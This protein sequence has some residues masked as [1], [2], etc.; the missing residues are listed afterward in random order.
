MQLRQLGRSPFQVAPLCLGGNV[1]GWTADEPTSFA[2][3]DAY[4][5]AGGNFV[6]T[7]DVYAR[8][9]PGNS[10][11]ESE[12]VLG[13]WMAARGNRGSVVIATKV[14]S[15]MGPDARGLSRR[16]IMTAVEDSLRRLQ[17][18][19]IDLYQAHR[20]DETTP[21]DETLGAFDEL[22]RQGKVRTIGASNFTRARLAEAHGVSE[23][24][25]YARY[26][27]LQPPYSLVDRGTYEPELE[28]YCREHDVGVITY[29]SLASGFLAGKYRPGQPLP[30][31][32][33]AQGIQSKFMNERGFRVLAE[34]DR[35]AAAHGVTP[36]Q[37]ALAW[38][39]ARPG[40]TAPIASATSVTQL[41]ELLGAIDLKLDPEAVSALDQAGA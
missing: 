39:I 17:T 30:S 36:A 10:G 32:P 40:I 15:E 6:D 20:D 34:V 13:R 23:E 16:Y 21:M 5:E 3:L 25:G 11:G 9:V 29:S 35:V 28:P 2:V 22:V 1:F 19:Y 7:A 37:V 41:Q 8:W 38:Q 31:T 14:G 18:D 24:H 4:V 26:E 27:S 12:T 33:R